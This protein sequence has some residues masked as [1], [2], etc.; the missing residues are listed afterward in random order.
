MNAARRPGDPRRRGPADPGAAASRPPVAA[1]LQPGGGLGAG[2]LAGE[3]GARRFDALAPRQGDQDPG[4]AHPPAAQASE[5]VA[6]ALVVQ[7]LARRLAGGASSWS[8]TSDHRLH[9]EAS[10]RVLTRASRAPLQCVVGESGRSAEAC[11]GGDSDMGLAY[12]SPSRRASPD[13]VGQDV[14]LI[15]AHMRRLVRSSRWGNRSQIGTVQVVGRFGMG[16]DAP[17]LACARRSR[18]FMIIG[19]P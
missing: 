12:R 7:A 13:G 8:T 3:R 18:V 10:A 19:P 11:G 9:A 14:V 5:H 16:S 15:D 17:G 1:A 2:G 4:R 6:D